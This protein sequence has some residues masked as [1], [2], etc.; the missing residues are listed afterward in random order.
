MYIKNI[1]IR[2]V[3][4]LSI[5]SSQYYQVGDQVQNFGSLICMNGNGND[6][7]THEEYGANKVIF[8]SIFATW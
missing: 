2:T 7:W 3:V 8:L 4:M 5:A 1:L 6:I